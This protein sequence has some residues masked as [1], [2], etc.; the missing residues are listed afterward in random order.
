MP[1]KERITPGKQEYARVHFVTDSGIIE[2]TNGKKEFTRD[3][4]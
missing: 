4:G 1:Y 2:L 3:R